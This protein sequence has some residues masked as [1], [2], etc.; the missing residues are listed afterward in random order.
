[1]KIKTVRYVSSL[2]DIRRLK[3]SLKKKMAIQEQKVVESLNIA[4][5]ITTPQNIYNE[6]L[7]SFKLEESIWT[8]LPLFLKYKDSLV[9]KLG[10]LSGKKKI[11]ILLGSAVVGVLGF[12][13]F[14]K[15]NKT[16]QEDENFENE[17][18]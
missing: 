17:D 18:L 10:N 15:M 11:W 6:M 1:M 4:R 8:L 7:K 12:F 3:R 2:E 16:S 5:V 13:I 9:Q 14:Q